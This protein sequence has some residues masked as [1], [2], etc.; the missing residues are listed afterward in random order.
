M[1][2]INLLVVEQEKKVKEKKPIPKFLIMWVVLTTIS[3][4]V[5]FAA[6][7]GL[8]WHIT[9]LNAEK[10]RNDQE[11]AVL[12]KKIEEVQRFEQLNKEFE[13]KVSLIENLRKNQAAPVLLLDE[14][15]TILTANDGVW[16][17]SLNYSVEVVS[18]DGFSYSNETL[19][20]FVD[21]L[22]K[23]PHVT[24]VNLAESN[25]TIQD[26]VTVY[27]FKLTYRFKV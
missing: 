23:S 22:K 6:Y 24:D 9:N 27:K 7:M 11:I 15:S 19:V 13:Q 21:A 10:T 12:K 25:R 3:A 8:D 14:L 4:A 18:L 20:S 1:I 5:A 2:R 26:N 16:L 17:T